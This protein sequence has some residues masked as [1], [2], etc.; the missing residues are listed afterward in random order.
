MVKKGLKDVEFIVAGTDRAS[1]ERNPC[2]SKIPLGKRLRKPF[3]CRVPPEEGYLCTLESR[4]TIT[5]FL[6][7]SDV[8]LIL[9]TFGGGTDTGEPP[10]I[11]QI[12][13]QNLF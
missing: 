4:E 11:A 6:R 1:L 13:T 10:A 12:K 3:D 5:R 8:V 2:P 7:G 9:A